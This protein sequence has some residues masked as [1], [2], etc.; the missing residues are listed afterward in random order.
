MHGRLPLKGICL[1]SHDPFKFLEISDNV[2]ETCKIERNSYNGRLIGNHVW[3]NEF[4]WNHYNKTAE[5]TSHLSFRPMCKYVIDNA[6]NVSRG[7]R[8]RK[9]SNS[10][11]NLQGHS[12]CNGAI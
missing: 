3:T 2:S 10:K 5:I 8:S 4:A 6:C 1:G 9:L 12:T 7:V 11:S